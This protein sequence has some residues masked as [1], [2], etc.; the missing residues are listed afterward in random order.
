MKVYVNQVRIAAQLINNIRN[1]MNLIQYCVKMFLKIWMFV[2]N[3]Y[4]VL[5]NYNITKHNFIIIMTNSPMVE[6][7]SLQSN[8][9]IKFRWWIFSYIS[10]I[11]VWTETFWENNKYFILIYNTTLETAICRTKNIQHTTL[12]WNYISKC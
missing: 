12:Y 5:L 11:I 8:H 2:G 4:V 6:L 1:E 3:L 10:K 9:C 7:L